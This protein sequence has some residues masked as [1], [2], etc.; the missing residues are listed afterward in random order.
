MRQILDV[1]PLTGLITWHEYD[2]ASDTTLIH[3]EQDIEPVLDHNKA[4]QN[5]DDRGW[6][7]T[8][9]LR[10]VGCIPPVIIVKWLTEDGINVFDRNHDDAV[11]RKLNDPDWKW[12]RTAPG[13]V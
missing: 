13:R 10:R 9:D 8:R 2:S 11:K 6:G 3:Y 4:L 1:D 5:E 7:K 12:L